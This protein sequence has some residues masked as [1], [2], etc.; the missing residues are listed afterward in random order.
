LAGRLA[1]RSRM[2]KRNGSL[3]GAPMKKRYRCT[4]CGYI[5]EGDGPPHECPVCGAR[6]EDFV[7][8]A[9]EAPVP[10]MEGNPVSQ[11]RPSTMFASPLGSKKGSRHLHTPHAAPRHSARRHCCWGVFSN[12]VSARTDERHA[13]IVG[14]S[15]VC[16]PLLRSVGSGGSGRGKVSALRLARS[17]RQEV[18]GAS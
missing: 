1:K 2:N 15:Q 17:R 13:R 9:G 11:R 18:L 5:H 6:R 3:S 10:A 7:F 4:I 8:E 12:Q 16:R 14:S